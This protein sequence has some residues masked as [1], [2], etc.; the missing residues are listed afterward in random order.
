MKQQNQS[1]FPAEVFIAA[2]IP[3]DAIVRLTVSGYF[4]AYGVISRCDLTNEVPDALGFRAIAEDN[5][6]WEVT[7]VTVEASSEADGKTESFEFNFPRDA[8]AKQKITAESWQHRVAVTEVPFVDA[9]VSSREPLR[10]CDL[11]FITHRDGHLWLEGKRLDWETKHFDWPEY[12]VEHCGE[13][14]R[15]DEFWWGDDQS[16]AVC[17]TLMDVQAHSF[18][19]GISISRIEAVIVLREQPQRWMEVVLC[20]IRRFGRREAENLLGTENLDA[21]LRCELW[22][23]LT[24]ASVYRNDPR[25]LHLWPADPLSLQPRNAVGNSI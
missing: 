6:F 20:F 2:G 12:W 21:V 22:E 24:L 1:A 9:A 14:C 17:D 11:V 25:Q 23:R 8:A 16:S 15:P 19:P 5:E 10:V 13:R 3:H 7:E 4:Y 18:A